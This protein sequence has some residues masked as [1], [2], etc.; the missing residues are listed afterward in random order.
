MAG[1]ATPSSD[2]GAEAAGV[3]PT[4]TLAVA[5]PY[6]KVKGQSHG[7]SK[8]KKKLVENPYAKVSD[9][10]SYRHRFDL[11]ADLNSGLL[12]SA[13]TTTSPQLCLMKKKIFLAT[14][15]RLSVLIPTKR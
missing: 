9:I 8:I 15:L 4:E 5:P 14:L 6:D 12:G 11:S 13:L 3:T 7:Y 1:V 10:F 2:G